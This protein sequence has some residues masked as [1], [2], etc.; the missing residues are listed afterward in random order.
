MTLL[1]NETRLTGT[2]QERLILKGAFAALVTDRAVQRM[3]SEEQLEDTVLGLLDLVRIRND[4]HTLA[5]RDEACW[6]QRGATRA[7][8]LNEAHPTHPNRLH[9]RVITKTRNVRTST[10]SRSDDHLA[11][12]GGD[13]TAVEVQR[14]LCGLDRGILLRHGDTDPQ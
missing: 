12:F 1:F 6:L 8:H 14:D 9:A 10:L 3:V 7:V 11:L 4:V 13:L 5:R 2:M